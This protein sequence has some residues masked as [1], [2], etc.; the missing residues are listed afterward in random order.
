MGDAARVIDWNGTDVPT[1]FTALPPGRYR[2]ELV[3]DAD[4]DELTDAERASALAGLRNI[5]AGRT[6][7][8]AE[9]DARMRAAIAS[10]T[11]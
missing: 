3:E 5:R 8:V 4:S 9:A 7:T 1:E 2:V 11:R 6:F 10:A